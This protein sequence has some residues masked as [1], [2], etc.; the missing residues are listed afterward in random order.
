MEA[1]ISSRAA[2][3][4]DLLVTYPA[5]IATLASSKQQLFAGVRNLNILSTSASQYSRKNRSSSSV[6][7]AETDT[8]FQMYRHSCADIDS[9]GSV[10]LLG[11]DPPWVC[12][13]SGTVDGHEAGS[14][15][16]V[17]PG[18]SLMGH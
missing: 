17:G 18:V 7:N 2:T 15:E 1:V 14:V 6:A 13:R 10:R 3:Q 11:F 5:A 9:S 16:W 4:Y 12:R 8:C